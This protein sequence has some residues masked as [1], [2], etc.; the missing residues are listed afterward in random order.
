MDTY[1]LLG[2]NAAGATVLTCWFEADGEHEARLIARDFSR[3]VAS[4]EIWRGD[5]C[6][7]RSKALPGASFNA[8][9]ASHRAIGWLL[10]SRRERAL[11]AVWRP[12][13]GLSLQS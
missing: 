9:A 11:A 2:Q 5:V 12:G 13:R 4:L 8:V 10:E 6:V 1:M 7:Y 3:D